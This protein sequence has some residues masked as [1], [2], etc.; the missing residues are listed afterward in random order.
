MNTKDEFDT[1]WDDDPTAAEP[2]AE[3]AVEPDESAADPEEGAEEESGGNNAQG[4]GGDAQEAEGAEDEGEGASHAEGAAE[5]AEEGSS[6]DAEEDIESLRAK[7]QKNEQRMK[8]WEGR[9]SREARERERLA[10]ENEQLKQRLQGQAP[11]DRSGP[12][13]TDTQD[14][15]ADTAG[16]PDADTNGPDEE[17]LQRFREEYGDE[18]ADYFEKRTRQIAEERAK[19]QMSALAERLTPLEEA[20]KEFADAEHSRKIQ[21]AHSDAFDLVKSGEIEQWIEGH[22]EFIADSMRKVYEDGSTDQVIELLNRY[23]AENK[24]GQPE[25]SDT[26]SPRTAKARAVRS[27]SGGPPKPRAPKDDFDAAWDQF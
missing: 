5:G 15:Q 12:A 23:K 3:P 6:D 24:S 10:R 14:D 19:S 9:L 21:E 25:S 16:G 27:R 2:T 17:E 1:A 26:S 13:K 4:D 8:S 18:M 7:L 20:Q 22:P 11:P